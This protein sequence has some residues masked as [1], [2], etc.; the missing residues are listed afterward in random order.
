MKK[1]LLIFILLSGC[2]SAQVD[3]TKKWDIVCYKA[4]NSF[5]IY[6]IKTNDIYYYNFSNKELNDFKQ[7][8]WKK[9]K[10]IPIDTTTIKAYQTKRVRLDELNERMI[11]E[12]N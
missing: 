10:E 7:M 12:L 3:S 9:S 6:T 4:I 11:K 2:L 1:L 8:F 5:Y